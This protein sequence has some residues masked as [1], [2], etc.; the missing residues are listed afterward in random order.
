MPLLYTPCWMI[1][2]DCT[3]LALCAVIWQ[4][5]SIWPAFMQEV[6][7]CCAGDD[8]KWR[9]NLVATEHQSIFTAC[10][11]KKKLH[12]WHLKRETAIYCIIFL[13][14]GYLSEGKILK[15]PIQNFKCSSWPLVLIPLEEEAF[16][17]YCVLIELS[18]DRL[19]RAGVL[20]CASVDVPAGARQR[21]GHFL[22]RHLD[23]SFDPCLGKESGPWQGWPRGLL[24]IGLLAGITI[25]VLD[26]L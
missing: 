5:I 19:S 13:L 23:Y 6:A 4:Y 25:E 22:L 16:F 2:E 26:C 8:K 10:Q 14:L 12:Q 20:L 11:E 17:A 18:K 3:P 9:A 21:G 7:L 24:H 15:R 1:S